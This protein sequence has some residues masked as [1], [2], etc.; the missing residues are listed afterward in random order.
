MTSDKIN[1]Q[2]LSQFLK[3]NRPMAPTP[4]K[5]EL[6]AI[7]TRIESEQKKRWKL[8]REIAVPAFV[9][10]CLLLM[11][12]TPNLRNH[13]RIPSNRVDANALETFLDETLSAM[14][15]GNGYANVDITI[16]EDWLRILD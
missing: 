11:I 15:N 1:D 4:D 13:L 2:K 9:A 6:E 8:W 5:D 7:L 3:S 16:G 10:A 14:D 12:L